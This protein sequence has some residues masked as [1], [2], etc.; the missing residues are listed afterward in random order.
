MY[1]YKHCGLSHI[2][3][4]NGYEESTYGDSITV[5]FHDI[6][7]LHRA[8]TK[9]LINADAPLSG[10]EFR[11]LRI[12]LDLSQKAIGE[13]MDKTDQA[14]AKW[15]K[16]DAV[17]VLADAAIRNLSQER[18]DG[19][20]IAGLLDKLKNLDRRRHEVTIQLNETEE[21]WQYSECA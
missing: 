19:T 14:I 2:F 15:E 12:E 21:G 4:K 1:H 18:L 7:G 17:P 20:A 13:L 16:D 5:A 9:R 8:I 3:L 11:F 10:E 6:D